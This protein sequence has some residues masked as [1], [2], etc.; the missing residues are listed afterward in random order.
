M[1]K[2]STRLQQ[3]IAESITQFEKWAKNPWRKF[4]IL[5]I[6]LL[7]GYLFGT[8]ITSISGVL[9]KMDP[10]S[11]LIVV[12]GAELTVRIRAKESAID[13]NYILRQ[14]LEMTRRGFLY[15]IFME[16]FKLI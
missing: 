1:R 10:I 5:I 11:A 6:S 7:L 9:G 8:V 2:Q 16:A 4:S 15:A 12:I 3:N 14:I 13:K